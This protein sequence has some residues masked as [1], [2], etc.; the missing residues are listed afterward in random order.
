MATQTKLWDI[1]IAPCTDSRCAT[2]VSK[3]AVCFQEKNLLCISTYPPNDTYLTWFEKYLQ[4]SQF[5][6]LHKCPILLKRL[7]LSNTE[8]FLTKDKSKLMIVKTFQETFTSLDSDFESFFES[9]TV[10]NLHPNSHFS[11]FIDVVTQTVNKDQTDQEICCVCANKKKSLNQE[12]RNPV[13][14]DVDQQLENDRFKIHPDIFGSE[15]QRNVHVRERYIICLGHEEYQ[16]SKSNPD[17]YLNNSIAQL[18]KTTSL[19]DPSKI[20]L[21]IAINVLPT[22]YREH[23]YVGLATLIT[24]GEQVVEE[25]AMTM[26]ENAIVHDR[27]DNDG[28][29]FDD[30]EKIESVLRGQITGLRDRYLSCPNNAF[31]LH[32]KRITSLYLSFLC[33]MVMVSQGDKNFDNFFK[34]MTKQKFQLSTKQNEVDNSMCLLDKFIAKMS[35]N[36][37]M[38]TQKIKVFPYVTHIAHEVLQKGPQNLISRD[39]PTQLIVIFELLKKIFRSLDVDSL[40]FLDQYVQPLKES[41]FMQRPREI[42]MFCLSLIF[43]CLVNFL[44]YRVKQTAHQDIQKQCSLAMDIIQTAVRRNLPE[45]VERLMQPLLFDQRPILRQRMA[46]FYKAGGF[47]Q[48]DFKTFVMN[49]VKRTLDPLL[50]FNLVSSFQSNGNWI[51]MSGRFSS[52][53]VLVLIKHPSYLDIFDNIYANQLETKWQDDNYLNELSILKSLRHPHIISLFSYQENLIPEF[54]ILDDYNKTNL[55]SHLKNRSDNKEYFPRDQL[56]NFLLNASSAIQYLHS[57]SLAHRNITA[58]SFYICDKHTVK[59]CGFQLCLRIVHEGK[60][61][62]KNNT[63][64]PSRWTAPESLDVGE[65]SKASDVWMFGHLM[66]EVLTHGMLPYSH[67]EGDEDDIL[68]MIIED[69]IALIQEKCVESGAYKIIG[70]CI[71]HDSSQRPKIDEIHSHLLNFLQGNMIR[72]DADIRHAYPDLTKQLSDIRKGATC[73][74]KSKKTKPKKKLDGLLAFRQDLNRGWSK[75]MKVKIESGVLNSILRPI[76]IL[77]NDNQ[78]H[79]QYIEFAIPERCMGSLLELSKN[80]SL[81]E[82][83]LRLYMYCIYQVAVKI[84]KLSH[85]S[86]VLGDLCADHVYVENTGEDLIVHIASLSQLAY[87]DK[88]NS[89]N[90]EPPTGCFL[91]RAPPEV[92]RNGQYSTAADV[93]YFGNFAWQVL[94]AFES[95]E[96]PRYHNARIISFIQSSDY[97]NDA[98]WNY[99]YTNDLPEGWKDGHP[100]PN[101]CSESFFK[102]IQRCVSASAAHRPNIDELVAHLKFF[103]YV[104]DKIRIAEEINKLELESLGSVSSFHIDCANESIHGESNYGNDDV[105]DDSSCGLNEQEDRRNSYIDDV[106][107]YEDIDYISV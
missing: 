84:Q 77:N 59:L 66:N 64:V 43:R 1:H 87:F 49:E 53:D 23:A 47:V 28:M 101:C 102:L 22:M 7:R 73:I 70:D 98:S 97:T 8:N 90:L 14:T 42:P 104:D 86:W 55:M 56:F 89:I 13:N 76:A 103:C 88:D 19:H 6:I 106:T 54:Y 62:D 27:G 18:K 69:K 29:G 34:K 58:S 9:F 61:I 65:Y 67:V 93:Y 72:S 30:L 11:A 96:M 81:G 32:I 52:T 94:H 95:V 39:I 60:C 26:L 2:E 51:E 17:K 78:K 38:A 16:N 20:T 48:K 57:E 35:R 24:C 41:A 37:C 85:V 63:D 5:T 83:N 80:K 10:Y 50:E 4:N 99:D 82:E 3:L 46:L 75:K 71:K 40:S 31:L 74:L 107:I 44:C 100:K 33:E 36:G 105:Y 92:K 12:Q 21:N 79:K 68:N 25:N 45:E 15:S 91:Q